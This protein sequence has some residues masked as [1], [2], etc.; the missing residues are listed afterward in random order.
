MMM[1]HSGGIGTA[2]GTRNAPNKR[3]RT[4][5]E[6]EPKSAISIKVNY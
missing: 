4:K 6:L 3:I 2:S 5:E 1:Y